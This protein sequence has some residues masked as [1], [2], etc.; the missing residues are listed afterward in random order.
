MKHAIQ[1]VA[2][3]EVPSGAGTPEISAPAVS[4]RV[5]PQRSSL[6]EE[7]HNRPSPIIDGGCQVTHF[8]VML[9]NNRE[10]ILEHV[11]DLCRRYS[12]PVPGFWWL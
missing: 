12:V 5:H 9:D 2:S 11:N 7:L 6:Y 3:E 4:L 1:D 10:G 8:T